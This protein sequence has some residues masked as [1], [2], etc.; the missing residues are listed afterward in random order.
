ML[1]IGYVNL[2][3]I[4]RKSD[5]GLFLDGGLDDK[6]EPTSILLPQRYVKPEMNIGD[7]IEVF[8]GL[9]SEDR[10]FASTEYPYV[11]VGEIE[12]LEVVATN[13]F[14]AFL[15]WGLPKDLFLPFIEQTH[16]VKVGDQVIVAVYLD[17]TGRIASSMRLSRHISKKKAEFKPNDQ[18]NAFVVEKNEL[19]FKVVVNDAHFGILYAN[20]VFEK[21]S[22]GQHLKVYVKKCRP[23]G[24]IDLYMQQLGYKAAASIE[25]KILQ[26]LEEDGFLRFN[27]KTTPDEIHSRFGVSKK[28]YKMAIG[29]LYKKRLISIDDSGIR[30]VK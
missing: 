11:M 8:V 2:L 10:L 30:L 22:V 19:G 26:V 17:N 13:Q 12:M 21:L 7:S 4:S 18:V 16:P 14:G 6:G 28:K 27:E 5:Y 9:D 24:K 3:K 15:D 29:G 25:E 23:D 20:E 1:N